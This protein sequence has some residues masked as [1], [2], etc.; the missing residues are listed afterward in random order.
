MKVISR[1]HELPDAGDVLIFGAGQGGWIVKRTLLAHGKANILGF[2]DNGRTGYFDGTPIFAP[3]DVLPPAPG[4]AVIVASMFHREIGE[5]LDRLGVADWRSAAPLIRNTQQAQRI[6]WRRFGLAK[7][8]GEAVTAVICLFIAV[9]ARFRRKTVDVGIGPEC[10]VNNR[11]HKKALQQAGYSAE[12]FVNGLTHVTSDFDHI[13]RQENTVWS[14]I[15]TRTRI[16]HLAATRYAVL[17]IYFGGCPFNHSV[18]LWRL[19]P[20]LFS[21]SRTRV[22]VMPYGQDVQDFTRCPNLPF[23]HATA[24]DYPYQNRRRAAVADRIDQWTRHADHVVSGCDWVDYMYHWDSLSTGHFAIDPDEAVARAMS[25]APPATS[26]NE[27][28]STGERRIK[29]VHAP[30]HR[31]IKGT[32]HIVAAVE[33]LRAEGLPIDLEIV[34]HAPNQVVLQ[35]MATADIVV[36]QLVI[37]WY[38]MVAIEAMALSKPV[39]CRLRPDLLEL[40]ETAGVL[41]AGETPLLTATPSTLTD[42]LRRLAADPDLRAA[43]G[44]R[45]RAYVERHHA[46]PRIGA[47]F[48]AINRSIGVY[49]GATAAEGAFDRRL[50]MR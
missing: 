1:P 25:G 32:P 17:Y 39:V 40:Y 9:I 14:E 35:R 5:Q 15:Y 46:L 50:R 24:M 33:R 16:F 12:T 29:I 18:W 41:T 49:P 44:R 2:V 20:L 4:V 48:A 36:D 27:N 7:R 31:T 28:L 13:Y 38:A 11:Y 34:E 42:V 23:K 37:G 6:G 19:E 45:G 26:E 10:L 21:I 47:D 3:T 30:N 8:L 43:A 22:V